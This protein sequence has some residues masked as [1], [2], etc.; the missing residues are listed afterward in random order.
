MTLKK[1]LV[2]NVRLK[3]E[4]SLFETMPFEDPWSHIIIERRKLGEELHQIFDQILE[5][6]KTFLN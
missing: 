5:Y 3:D 1:Y 4:F 2:F 6:E